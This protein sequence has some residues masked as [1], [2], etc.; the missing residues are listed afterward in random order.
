MT[1]IADVAIQ[2]K[3]NLPIMAN[4]VS[5]NDEAEFLKDPA[6]LGEVTAKNTDKVLAAHGTQRNFR[7]IDNVEDSTR[8]VN[9]VGR[10]IVSGLSEFAK[11]SLI[12]VK[13]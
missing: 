4:I 5:G 12:A 11:G 1:I 13:G 7:S 10:R 2:G 9:E 3:L 8:V 6:N